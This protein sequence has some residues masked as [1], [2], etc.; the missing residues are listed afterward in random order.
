MALRPNQ[1]LQIKPN[2]SVTE[3]A[4]LMAAKR[5]DC[6]LVTDDE[7]R[8][9]GIFTAKDL[10]FRV[11]GEGLKANNVTIAEIMTKNPLCAKTYALLRSGSPVTAIM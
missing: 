7:D 1:A 5:E 4:Q 11:V 3:A 6:V 10:A 9:A 8:I 2:T